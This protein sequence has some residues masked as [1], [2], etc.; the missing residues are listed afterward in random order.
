MLVTNQRVLLGRGV[1]VRTERS[2][3]FRRV[4]NAV[5]VRLGPAGYCDVNYTTHTSRLTER[6]GPLSPPRA[7]Q[8]TNAINARV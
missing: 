2:I 8:F 5:Y 3:P 1:F 6:L 7:R 4:E